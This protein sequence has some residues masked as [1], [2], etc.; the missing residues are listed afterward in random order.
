MREAS[1]AV[2]VFGEP[3]VSISLFIILIVR[4]EPHIEMVVLDNSF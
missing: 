3:L 2:D 1:A 4:F